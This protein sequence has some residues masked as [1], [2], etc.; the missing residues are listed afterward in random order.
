VFFI[1]VG[2][3]MEKSN[4]NIVHG[5][6]I[7]TKRFVLEKCLKCSKYIKCHSTGLIKER[8]KILKSVKNIEKE[9]VLKV[10]PEDYYDC[11]NTFSENHYFVCEHFNESF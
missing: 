1:F 4:D 3:K 11:E 2:G 8:M 6:R 5:P 9:Y 7:Q 10:W